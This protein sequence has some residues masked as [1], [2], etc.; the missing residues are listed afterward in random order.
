MHPPTGIILSH[1]GR[2]DFPHA[3]N[4]Q[5]GADNYSQDIGHPNFPGGWLAHSVKTHPCF[6]PNKVS[7]HG[8]WFTAPARS[9]CPPL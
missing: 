5:Y 7:G 3:S 9:Y 8:R 2:L 4:T 6:D 1:W